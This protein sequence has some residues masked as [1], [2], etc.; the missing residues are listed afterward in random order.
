MS[1]TSFSS[2]RQALK[3][4]ASVPM[5]PLGAMAAGSL[6]SGCASAV[7]GGSTG[8]ASA[9]F[10]PMAAPSLADAAAMATTTVGSSLQ[11]THS[12]GGVDT[13]KLAYRS[14]FTTGDMVPDGTGGRILS[15]GYYDI[16][17]RPII[18]RS[19]PGRE[20][21]FFSDCPDGTSLLQL[22]KSSVKGV[23]GNAVFAVVQFEYT[24]QNQ[25]G[26]S[27]YGTLPSPI[28]VLTLDQD[29]KTG[30]LEHLIGQRPV[31]YLRRKPVTLEYPSVE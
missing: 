3:M 10:L 22:A 24:S 18:D 28:A 6:L 14:F 2:R 11:V 19:V 21:H 7:S 8:F 31:D 15:G 23:K 9:R 13:Y 20:R 25:K 4:L 30:K 1:K 5:L 27:A 16:V 17:N 29:P 26:D 12:G